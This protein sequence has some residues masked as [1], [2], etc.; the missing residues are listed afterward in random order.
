M[1]SGN[2]SLNLQ[3]RLEPEFRVEEK[4]H[5]L[6]AEIA[7][8]PRAVDD[9]RH[10][11]LV[12][13][14]EPR[15]FFKNFPL[16]CAHLLLVLPRYRPSETAKSLPARGLPADVHFG[17]NDMLPVFAK[18]NGLQDARRLG[19]EMARRESVFVLSHEIHRGFSAS[20]IFKPARRK[21]SA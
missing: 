10:R 7:G 12:Q 17:F 1:M 16:F 3:V 18:V 19:R 14:F 11:D 20:R 8:N 9:Q 15:G 5:V 6:D 4:I 2:S 13:F 21:P